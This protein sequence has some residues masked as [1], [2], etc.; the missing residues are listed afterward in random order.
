MS[1]HVLNCVCGEPLLLVDGYGVCPACGERLRHIDFDTQDSLRQQ[2]REIKLKRHDKPNDDP[3]R[4]LTK[5]RLSVK[6]LEPLPGQ[7]ELFSE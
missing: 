3:E 4:P 7:Q 1:E 6:A 5:A 2:G